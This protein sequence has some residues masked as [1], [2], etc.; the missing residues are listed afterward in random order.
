MLRASIRT[1]D[2]GASPHYLLLSHKMTHQSL[3]LLPLAEHHHSQQQ[4]QRPGPLKLLL[5]R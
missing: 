4:T 3:P 1:P 2:R 5:L